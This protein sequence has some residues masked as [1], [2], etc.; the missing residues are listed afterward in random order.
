MV[1]IKLPIQGM[2]DICCDTGT[3][4]G[5]KRPL[6]LFCHWNLNGLTAHNFNKLK[7][8]QAYVA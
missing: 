4:P 5:Q 2:Q 8:L 7:L 6:L 3:N 1:I